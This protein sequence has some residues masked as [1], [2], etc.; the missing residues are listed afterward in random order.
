[1]N[2]LDSHYYTSLFHE[3]NLDR[4]TIK[5]LFDIFELTDD[6]ENEKDYTTYKFFK[7][8][9]E[10]KECKINRIGLN[11]INLLTINNKNYELT[12]EVILE[13]ENLLLKKNYKKYTCNFLLGSDKI[14]NRD[15][16]IKYSEK[17]DLWEVARKYEEIIW[18]AVLFDKLVGNIN[19]L[20]DIETSIKTSRP[21]DS[22]IYQDLELLSKIKFLPEVIFL[23]I[24]F[25]IQKYTIHYERKRSGHGDS[26]NYD[27]TFYA[28][29]FL[30]KNPICQ[31]IDYLEDY[32]FRAR[33]FYEINKLTSFSNGYF[34]AQDE[35]YIRSL[36]GAE[37][38]KL[39]KPKQN[40]SSFCYLKS[41]SLKK[42]S[43]GTYYF[44]K[45][46]EIKN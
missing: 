26:D 12:D 16:L 35:N 24:P 5:S 8:K 45:Y 1:M 30:L 31:E 32:F 20:S 22:P 17:I 44:P 21:Y 27:L 40:E 38:K 2:K 41:F 25:F 3:T 46:S 6:P 15:A 18:D 19:C 13:F 33:K 4:N 34:K 11:F 29:D 9:N 43:E 23:F 36:L 39:E 7:T 10:F 42:E 14:N 37:A 28:Y